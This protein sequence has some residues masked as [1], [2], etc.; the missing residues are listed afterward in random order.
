MRIVVTGASGMIGRFVVA[1]LVAHAHEVD[2]LTRSGA[3]DSAPAAATWH[4]IDIRDPLAMAA[5]MTTLRPDA[6]IHLAA[7]ATP[8][9]DPPFT[10]FSTNTEA[11]FVTLESAGIAGVRRVVIASSISLLGLPFG[12]PG[13][14]P[15]YA[16]VD[17]AH[18]NVGTDPYALSKEVD[19]A[20]AAMMQRRHG[21]QVIALRIPH[22]RDMAGQRLRSAAVPADPASFANELWAY[23]DAADAARAFGLS[24][25]RE[26]PGFTVINVMAPDTYSPEDSAVLMARFH[27]GTVIRRPLLGR[28][29][30]FDLR[31][32]RDLLGFTPATMG[33]FEPAAGR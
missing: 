32:C 4:T 23:L 15:L 8:V 9:F 7:I 18:P 22:T 31:R 33:P 5:L 29:S 6:V 2:A 21:F 1:D 12:E 19:E 14:S 25:E 30:I 3:P 16:P 24:V 28:E 17:E 20:T 13:L 27:P 26:I 11:T 10:V